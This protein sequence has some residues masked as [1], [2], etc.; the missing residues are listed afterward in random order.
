MTVTLVQCRRPGRCLFPEGGLH[1]TILIWLG[2]VLSIPVGVVFFVLLLVTL[3]LLQ[4]SD[5][6]LNPDYYPEQL[7]EA[8]IYEFVLNDLLTSAIDERRV[9]E[10]EELARRAQQPDE[11]GEDLTKTPLISSGLTTEE[12]VTSVNRAVPPDW[13]QE[14]VEQS[15]DEIGNY[16]SGE[17]D[18]FAF[19]L[20]AGDRV[21]T[22][23]EE[24]KSLIR[25][26]DAYEVLF[27]DVITPAIEEAV[28]N[29]KLPLGVEFTT[30]RLVQAARPV[31]PSE[32]VQEQVEIVLDELAPYF[33]G[34][35]DTFTINL[36]LADRADIALGEVKS[37]LRETDFGEL[38]YT[39][40]VEPQLLKSLG[41]AVQL[42]L[43]V[44]ITNEEVLSA[45]RQVSPPSW[46]EEA[47]ADADRRRQ[48]IP[49][50]QGGRLLL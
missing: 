24:F 35:R 11:S 21:E 12:I 2:R 43:G 5:T 20:A 15:F 18:Q 16:L 19:T 41:Q 29:K 34:D 8:N 49:D 39:E 13:V 23:V 4:I 31:V 47:S 26:S 10:A 33:V 44:A 3:L 37:L 38:L 14:R 45:L 30:E 17:R 7:S 28:A 32:W 27:Q 36:P 25:S 42:P 22:L 6:F 1:Y 50:G 48:P 46:V 9:R 40:V